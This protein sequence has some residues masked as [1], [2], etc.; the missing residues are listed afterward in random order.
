METPETQ[1]EEAPRILIVDDDESLLTLIAMRLD[2][3]GFDTVTA[4][5]AAEALGRLQAQRPQLAVLDLRLAAPAADTSTDDEPEAA[6]GLALFK[7]MRELEPQL[8][9]IILTA[10][11]S[12][13]DAVQ[14]TRDGVAAFFTKPF[15][16]RALVEEIRRQLALR[17]PAAAQE[18]W[19]ARI[20]TRNRTMLALI[21]EIGRV[22]QHEANVLIHGPSGSGKELIAQALHA[23]SPRAAKP[24]VAVN[25]AAL[26][27]PLLESELFGHVKGAFSGA[28]SEHPG[29]LR[30]AAGGTVL[31]DEIGDMPLLLQAKLLRAVEQRRVRPVGG[32][33]EIE[34][35]VRLVAATHRD[36][37]QQVKEGRF[38]EDLFYRLNVVPLLLPPLDAR[39]D[40]VPLLAQHFLRLI[41]ERYDSPVKDF[42]PEALQLL[43]QAPWPGNVR[44]LANVVEQ[45][46]VLADSP[47]IP[48]ALVA[49]ALSTSTTDAQAVGIAPLAQARAQ[50]EREYLVQLLKLT[51][52][53]VAQAARLAG[54]NRTEFYRL[55]ERHGLASE[56]FR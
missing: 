14:A 4:R 40:D 53:S 21:D 51:G 42:A 16:G 2:A 54:R 34:I 38:R 37:A 12:I 41:A 22:A 8:P 28:V 9:V 30:T 29:L 17:A 24:F 48:A 39:R 46:V 5:N 52:G 49:R 13:P 18:G 26:P 50:F 15:D 31:L 11:G 7:R 32:A 43:A 27:E 19:R 47:L 55:I 44:Q 6:D 36:L 1:T 10:H 56:L 45:C 23:A 3:S 20:V 33:R 35:D 25:C